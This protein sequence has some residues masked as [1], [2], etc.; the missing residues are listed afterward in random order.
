MCRQKLFNN[1]ILSS[2]VCLQI[3]CTI[4]VLAQQIKV[5]YVLPDVDPSSTFDQCQ[6]TECYNLTV[7]LNSNILSDNISSTK[8]I[9]YPGIHTVSST[10]NQVFSINNATTFELTTTNMS[11]SATIKCDGNIGFAFSF[12]TNLTISGIT[13]EG[14]GAHFKRSQRLGQFR[15]VTS[16][17]V[18]L[19]F[20]SINVHLS[21]VKVKDG[22]GIGLLAVNAHGSFDLSDSGFTNNT[23]NLYYFSD[24]RGNIILNETVD[25]RIENSQFNR[26]TLCSHKDQLIGGVRSAGVV[27]KLFQTQFNVTV[28]VN[29]ITLVKNQK[30]NLVFELDYHTSKVSIENITSVSAD[31]KFGMWILSTSFSTD[32][33]YSSSGAPCT[34]FKINHAHFRRGGVLITNSGYRQNQ[35]QHMS[36]IYRYQILLSNIII[37]NYTGSQ[38]S[39]FVSEAP[40]VIVSN[41][42]IR[43][44]TDNVLIK[45]CNVLLRGYFVYQENHG[46]I[47]LLGRNKIVMESITAIV[48]Q[49]TAVLYAPVFITGSYIETQNS[50]V[51]IVNNT[52]SDGGGVI[53]FNSTIAFEGNSQ[54]NFLYNSGSRGGAMTFYLKS[55]LIFQSG[56]T[57]LTFVGNHANKRGGAIFVQDED[58]VEYDYIR[59]ITRIEYGNFYGPSGEGVSHFHFSK[60][61]AIEAG[62]AVYGGTISYDNF[63]FH[64]LSVND[65]SIVSS[66]PLQ[67]CLCTTN[68]KP[69]CGVSRI[70]V[71]LLPG[72]S[73]ELQA[74]AV[75]DKYGNQEYGTVPA[76][77]RASF[78]EQSQGHLQQ[79]EYVQ[80]TET[81]CTKL[82]YT[83]HFSSEYEL[84]QLT[85]TEHT[86]KEKKVLEI[87]F[88]RE[89]CS[90]GFMYD[91]SMSICVCDKT[92][93]DQGI[94]CDINTLTVYRPNQK[95]I[96]T[97]FTHLRSQSQQPGVLVHD[98]CPF[99]YCM[100][101]MNGNIQPLNLNYPNQQCAFNRSGILCGACKANFSNALGTSKCIQCNKPWMALIVPLVAIAGVALVVGLIFL[102][103]TVSVGTI[104]GLV[105]YANI[106]RANHA[107]F[108]PHNLSTS[109]LSTFIA[110]LNLDLGI[111]TCFY[112]GLNAYSKTWFQFLF[113]LY[114]WFILSA[115]IVVSHYSTRVS[116]LVGN[117][118]VQ[119]L[120][121]LFLLSYAKLL[122]I[123][124]T[125][126]SS[127]ELVYPNGYHRRIWLYDGNV[128][129]LTGKHIALF[130]AAL[131]LL[132]LISIPFTVIL[133]CIQW[134]QKLSNRKPLFWVKRLQ[135]LFDAFTGPYKIKHRYWTGLL[136]LIRVCLF[137][138]FSFNTTGN[139]LINVLAISVSMSCLFAYLSLIGGVYKLWWLNIIETSFILNLLILSMATF[140]QINAAI[141]IKPITYTSTGITLALFVAIILYHIVMKVLNTKQGQCLIEELKHYLLTLKKGKPNMQSG[142]GIDLIDSEPKD[143]VTYSVIQLEEN[144]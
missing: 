20:H 76:T 25:I 93:V 29:N 135:P 123:I 64:D 82:T 9:L 46:S 105:F 104:N 48:M 115:I 132:I 78:T 60:N 58:Y 81:H 22:S 90:V 112:D 77:V 66:V 62:S 6:A 99:D 1:N 116:R 140:Y 94:N 15:T 134:L 38:Y 86:W 130:I 35:L 24:D 143:K 121:T 45:N 120:A 80:S 61:T 131:I 119:V 96:S 142:L 95:W 128:D 100:I 67:V 144:H 8:I 124:I 92:L 10:V 4:L 31:N 18:L 138:V 74:I 68:S 133:F 102:N 7:L 91:T 109:F 69:N 44:T 89:N 50:S 88:Q 137:L 111:E 97:T 103:L 65:A 41:I 79:V 56:A 139:P 126:F 106:V 83:V 49:N 98:H 47:L 141:S 26:A 17:F 63:H 5:I 39:L 14:C 84:L 122:R 101:P 37:E 125:V 51:S 117:N 33:C 85:T 3:S 52:G 70:S 129:Y 30:Y 136:L 114:I 113:P 43:N 27:F 36:G 19:I 55:V 42:T 40:R 118:A 73:Y 71:E 87:L 32:K 53:L 23:C 2:L 59:K 127:T 28:I 54:V 21:A 72:Q 12:C 107:V 57:N 13:F 16:D 34:V 108:F 75:G 110:W 11:D